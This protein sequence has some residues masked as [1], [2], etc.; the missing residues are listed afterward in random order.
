[1]VGAVSWIWGGQQ[2]EAR[3]RGIDEGGGGFVRALDVY[4]RRCGSI[5]EVTTKLYWKCATGSKKS[6]PM[7][8]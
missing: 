4:G 5:A 7:R 3:R 8:F 6:D 1:M 2:E